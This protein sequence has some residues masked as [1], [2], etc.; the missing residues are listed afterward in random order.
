MFNLKKLKVRFHLVDGGYVDVKINK[1]DGY[2]FKEF[3]EEYMFNI[4]D[5]EKEILVID[6]YC[7]IYN[8]ITRFYQL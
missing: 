4:K 8:K 3:L 2:T 6:N 5:I 7:I 1:E